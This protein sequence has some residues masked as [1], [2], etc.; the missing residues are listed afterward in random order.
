LFFILETTTSRSHAFYNI[1]LFKAGAPDFVKTLEDRSYFMAPSRFPINTAYCEGW[2]LYCEK[3]G[4]DMGLYDDPYDRFGHYS[5]EMFRAC[6]LVTELPD[7]AT[8][9]HLG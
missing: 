1:D 5:E 4:F 6:R 2:A 3:L 8:F 9:Q 7:W